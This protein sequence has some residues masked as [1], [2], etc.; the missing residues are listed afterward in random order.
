MTR[1][2]IWLSDHWSKLRICAG[3][4]AQEV[5]TISGQGACLVKTEDANLQRHV[6]MNTWHK[7]YAYTLWYMYDILCQEH[8]RTLQKEV[9]KRSRVHIIVFKRKKI[10]YTSWLERYVWYASLSQD[11]I[12]RPFCGATTHFESCAQKNGDLLT[13]GHKASQNWVRPISDTK[14]VTKTTNLSRDG[15]ALGI[16]TIYSFLLQA[17]HGIHLSN[18]QGH[19]QDG[20]ENLTDDE[21]H[22]IPA[23]DIM[24]DIYE[25]PAFQLQ[26]LKADR[27]GKECG[28][29][30]QAIRYVW[31][32]SLLTKPGSNRHYHK[33]C[34][35]SGVVQIFDCRWLLL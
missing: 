13:G 16:Q 24:Y 18:I 5:K 30:S 8:E 32:C 31:R 1:H 34:M 35:P 4:D 2:G 33:I 10:Y 9:E 29:A 21:D 11:C 26:K 23:K 27:S 6:L 15:N 28:C 3:S 12:F 22:V 19:R 25:L 14:I 20:G 17:L 7:Q